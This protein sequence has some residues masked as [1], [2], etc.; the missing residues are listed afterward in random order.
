MLGQ[1]G[2]GERTVTWGKDNPLRLA[3]LQQMLST[4]SLQT[5][6]CCWDLPKD[7][8]HQALLSIRVAWKE[9]GPCRE[10]ASSLDTGHMS[11]AQCSQLLWGG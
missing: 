8:V 11:R 3:Y 2:A 4:A 5:P 9:S 7:L 10:G 1:D 6:G